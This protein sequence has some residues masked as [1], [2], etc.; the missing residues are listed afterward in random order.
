LVGKFF[1]KVVFTWLYKLI[2]GIIMTVIG[3]C[4]MGAEVFQP[5]SFWDNVF[6]C[7]LVIG[8]GIISIIALIFISVGFYYWIKDDILGR[9]KDN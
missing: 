7:I 6:T 5:Y 1:Q 3:V 9:N 4:V 8:L 2:A